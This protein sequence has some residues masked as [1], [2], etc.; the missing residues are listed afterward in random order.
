MGL[1]ESGLTGRDVT[2]SVELQMGL[3][4]QDPE[5]QSH[6]ASMAGTDLAADV[7]GAQMKVSYGSTFIIECVID[8]EETGGAATDVLS[9]LSGSPLDI[10]P[11]FDSTATAL[12]TGAPFKFKVI[13][14]ICV[15]LDESKASVPDTILLQKV[16]SDLTTQTDITD[17]MSLNVN[18]DNNVRATLLDQ[19]A[20]VIDIKENLR[21]DVVLASSTNHA[22]V[23]KAYIT[24]MRCVADE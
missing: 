13:D 12:T 20:C 19:D 1:K 4:L 23:V 5:S 9:G 14:V 6:Q 17:A 24:C 10:F 15:L 2:E 22:T 18:A 16:N 7:D 21:W 8:T 3:L 11:V